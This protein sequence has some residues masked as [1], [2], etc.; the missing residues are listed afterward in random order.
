MPFLFQGRQYHRQALNE[1]ERS[2]FWDSRLVS[3]VT[4]P[5]T[6]SLQIIATG[7]AR[8]RQLRSF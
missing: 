1:Q 5:L 4:T 7:V 6:V 3:A 8:D 2:M